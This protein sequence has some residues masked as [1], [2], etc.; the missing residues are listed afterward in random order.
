[1]KLTFTIDEDGVRHHF[2]EVAQWVEND[3]GVR[4]YANQRLAHYCEP[5]VP[6][7]TGALAQPRITSECITYRG[8]YAH[9]QY[10]GVVY[11]PNYPK[12]EDGVIVGWVSPPVKYP[13]SRRLNYSQD[14]HPLA[15]AHWDRAAM[16]NYSQDLADDVT[17]YAASK[18]AKGIK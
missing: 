16:A 11:G 5:Y 13:T 12:V 2:I 17:R 1:M 8:P 18:I 3:K 6:M 15:Q 7:D 9:Y 4:L 10:E 14:A